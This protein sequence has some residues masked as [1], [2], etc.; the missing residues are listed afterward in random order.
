MKRFIDIENN[1]G[2]F[3]EDYQRNYCYKSRNS[4]ESS[5][6]D[7]PPPI[8][9][10]KLFTKNFDSQT[11]ISFEETKSLRR[12]LSHNSVNTEPMKVNGLANWAI[13]LSKSE[14]DLLDLFNHANF[15]YY[16]DEL[17]IANENNC[18]VKYYNDFVIIVNSKL[19]K[20]IE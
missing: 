6:C 11:M 8:K 2:Q 18:T 1:I 19:N 5:Y 13:R 3:I 14:S 15:N 9:P 12:T 4:K 7:K 10:Y 16:F 17:S 20:E